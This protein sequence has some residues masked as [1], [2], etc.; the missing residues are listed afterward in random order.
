MT[1]FLNNKKEFGEF[2]FKQF[3]TNNDS[4]ETAFNTPAKYGKVVRTADSCE[5]N[6]KNDLGIDKTFDKSVFSEFTDSFGIVYLKRY[7]EKIVENSETL[8]IKYHIYIPKKIIKDRRLQVIIGI[9]G[10][11]VN[12]LEFDEM[13]KNCPFFIWINFDLLG[14]GGSDCP[15]DF[16]DNR[17]NSYWSFELLAKVIFLCKEQVFKKYDNLIHPTIKPLIMGSDWGSAVAQKY[18]E[19]YNDSILASCFISSVFFDKYWVQQIGSL[20]ALAK[21]KYPSAE[22][23]LNS[24]MFVDSF[25]RLLETMFHTTSKIHNQ[26]TLEKFQRYYVDTSDYQNDEKTPANTTYFHARIRVLAQMASNLLGKGQLLPLTKDNKIGIDF[27][28]FAKPVF[29]AHGENDKM[30]PLIDIFIFDRIL[31]QVRIF[32]LKN[33]GN[34]IFQESELTSQICKIPN[35]GHFST[36]D[37]Y[38]YFLEHFISWVSNIILPDQ[39]N[40]VSLGFDDV[41]GHGNF[42]EVQNSD[43]KFVN[44]FLN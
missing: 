9:H 5:I 14:M 32:Q 40:K 41:I 20:L 42:K 39:I 31:K 29:L 33:R 23:K 17:G 2:I 36:S 44:L 11:P 25:T 22:F 15:L 12:S 21:L 8:N 1:N 7:H 19:L 24:I 37:N 4:Q 27:T 35:A 10:V 13:C 3:A 16:E 26:I 30:M 34:D 6:I 43:V 38:K 18:T 28:R